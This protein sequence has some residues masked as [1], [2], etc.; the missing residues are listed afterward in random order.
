MR[1]KPVEL[2]DGCLHAGAGLAENAA[3]E[4]TRRD[5]FRSYDGLDFPI[6]RGDYL[7]FRFTE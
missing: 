4:Q 1:E 2:Q 5:L 3:A 7:L 6:R